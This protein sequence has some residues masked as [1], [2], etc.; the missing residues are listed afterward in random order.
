M[1]FLL[2]NTP[3]SKNNVDTAVVWRGMMVMK[4]V[5]QL[6]FDVDWTAARSGPRGTDDG[7]LDVL[8]VDTPPGTGDVALSLGQLIIVD[9]QFLSFI[10]LSRFLTCHLRYRLG[11]RLDTSR[12]CHYRHEERSSHVQE[13]LNSSVSNSG[14]TFRIARILTLLCYRSQAPSSTCPTSPARVRQPRT[15]SLAIQHLSRRLAGN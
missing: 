7:E 15:T 8:V 1:G 12:C 11:H 3:E 14:C 13:D 4:A 6:L 2:P 9:G 5:Q 10:V